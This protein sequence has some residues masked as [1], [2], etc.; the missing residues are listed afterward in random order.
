[1]VAPD[2]VAATIAEWQTRLLQLDRRN[3][4]L[5]FKAGRSSVRISEVDLDDFVVRLADSRSGLSFAYV[6][7]T[8]RPRALDSSVA[9]DPAQQSP[10]E[11]PGDIVADCETAD[12]QRRLRNLHRKDREWE[13]EQGV[14]ILFLAVGFLSWIDEDGESA[15]A[16]ILLA[17][18][19]LDQPSPR[20]P[21]R[22][23]REHDDIVVNVTLQYKLSRLNVALPD[24]DGDRSPSDFLADV[25][26]AIRSKPQW[27]VK[28]ELV[29]STFHY[30]KMSMWQDLE[31]L[32]L[33]GVAH[34]LVR[35]LAG[36]VSAQKLE[37][38]PPDA[39]FNRSLDELAGG[40]LDDA[41]DLQNQFLILPA[42]YSQIM[43]VEAARSGQHL[44]IHGP[45]GTGKS[46]TIANI[47]A[48]FLADG[49]RV[50]FVS[51]KTAALDV[52]KR[53]L[54]ECNLGTFCLDLHSV[55]GKKSNVYDQLRMSVDDPRKV[56]R[57]GFDSE[58]L[59][60]RRTA[61][62]ELVRAL[63]LVRLP[64]GRSVFQMN[65]SLAALRNAPDVNFSV[66]QPRSLTDPQ[67]RDFIELATRVAQRAPEFHA[68]FTSRWRPLRDTVSKVRLPDDIRS[69]MRMIRAALPP[70]RQCSSA[71]SDVTGLPPAQTLAQLTALAPVFNQLAVAPGVPKHW[72]SA[73]EISRLL[74][75]AVRQEAVKLERL[76]LLAQLAEILGAGGSSLN[77]HLL[78]PPFEE[79]IRTEEP[80]RTLLGDDWNIRLLLESETLQTAL[81]NLAPA[82]IALTQVD[83]RIADA[84]GLSPTT[85]RA[86]HIALVESAA[87]VAGLAPLPACWVLDSELQ[88][89]DSD[90]TYGDNRVEPSSDESRP[91]NLVLIESRVRAAQQV[92]DLLITAEGALFAEYSESL[93]ERVDDEMLI[94]YRTDHRRFLHR[95]GGQFKRDQRL[96]QGSRIS[97]GKIS[98]DDATAAVESALNVAALQQQWA[99][100]SQQLP[101]W[102]GHRFRGRE[103]DWQSI[104]D[105]LQRLAQIVSSIPL[106]DR[107]IQSLT[108]VTAGRSLGRLVRD[109]GD[110]L[111]DLS[112]VEVQLVG[113]ARLPQLSHPIGSVLTLTEPA[114]APIQAILGLAASLRPYL[115]RPIANVS[116]L[117]AVLAS[118]VKLEEIEAA[119]TAEASTLGNAFGDRF[120]GFETDWDDVE[121]AL[122]WAGGFLNILPPPL[123][124]QLIEQAVSPKTSDFYTQRRQEL[125]RSA[126]EC[127]AHLKQL[128]EQ[129][130]V[131][132]TAWGAWGAAR[133]S[134]LEAWADD[135]ET[136]ADSAGDW[137][138]Y[139]AYVAALENVTGSGVVSSIRE[140]TDDATLI[141]SVVQRRLVSAWLDDT[142]ATDAV[143]QQFAARE[144]ERVKDEFAALDRQFPVAARDEVRR[145][146]FST[147]PERYATQAGAGQ[148]GTL[149]AQL[150]RKRGQLPIRK[151]F[152]R[153]PTLLQELKP[154]LMM[155]PLAV[156]QL[157]PRSATASE[158]LSFDAVIF[159]EAS[160][161]FPEDAVPSLVR[162]QQAIVVGD[163]RQLPPTSFFRKAQGDE[164]EYSAEQEEED[165]ETNALRG[166]D[167][168][169]EAMDGMLGRGVGEKYLA[170]HYRSRHENLIRFSNHHFYDDRLLVFPSPYVDRS[171]LGVRGLY[172]EDGR[173][174]A[175]A[176]RTNQREADEVVRLVFEH[177]RTRPSNES[178][179]VVTLSR[180]QA[181]L[182][183][184]MIVQ[185]RI[186]E[187]DADERFDSAIREPFFVKNL[188][189]VQGDERDHI[190]LSV[191][192]GPTVGSGAVP[193]RFGPIN[194]DGGDRRLNVAV[195]RAR[196]SMTVV[197]S[198]RA[199][200]ITSQQR[201]SLLLRRYLEY[202]ANPL[203]AF[204]AQQTVDPTAEAE[205]PFEEA[206]IRA[207][208]ARGHRV[209]PQ[210]GV[211]GFRIDLG[212]YSQEGDRFDLGVECDGYTYHSSPAARDRDWLRQSILEGLGWNIHRVW[213][214][215]WIRNPD[216]QIRAIED[217]LQRA[218]IPTIAG[219]SNG[220]AVPARAPMSSPIDPER[221]AQPVSLPMPA[222]LLFEE[223]EEASLRGMR[224]GPELQFATQSE[225]EP[226]ILRIAE[227]EGPVHTDVAID[228][229]RQHYGMGKARQPSR[230]RV[231]SAV[232]TLARQTKLQIEKDSG[233]NDIFFALLE[234]APFPRRSGSR[235]GSRRPIN[236]IALSE[237]EVG[238]ER[239]ASALHGATRDELIEE[240]ARQFGYDRTGHHIAQRLGIAITSLVASG[241]LVE[242][243]GMLRLP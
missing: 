205:S 66:P 68:H 32:R 96:L 174:D 27:A 154:C 94:R 197:H 112:A 16:P 220:A 46:Q 53:R 60:R 166:R 14:N 11:I 163:E 185:R 226:I 86:S 135:L 84:M 91:S 13:E 216:E 127:D 116:E 33:E 95:F 133:W 156:S 169:L 190:I 142:Y 210:V 123:S 3:N 214:T 235:S 28:H 147:Y 48:T 9:T 157:L 36:D 221:D 52:V 243:F 143:F 75:I 30:S 152:M 150:S 151:L 219:A 104:Y 229:I 107:L 196:V 40:R 199:T 172:L 148:I 92:R 198:L 209:Q 38:P 167:S 113:E 93:V 240:T 129:F 102:L 191:G 128:N 76:R 67:Y 64:L 146:V 70:V 181:D 212:I 180:A 228:R 56:N 208:V 39:V 125:E 160:Q 175:G 77:F 18:C 178:I 31:Q 206:V 20:D 217:A 238:L 137:V 213:S 132:A 230:D 215:A 194:A 6:D 170:V 69:H 114:A 105:A 179:G 192:Y 227:V 72:L 47:I 97:P 21:F 34:A 103:T 24:F 99:S 4:L 177:M 25:E 117:A 108:N 118:G 171:D 223:Y 155:S 203:G 59:L 183:D 236:H 186:L 176:S 231:L 126:A 26:A 193:N 138:Q 222:Q 149:K 71:S 159:D 134:E 50:L 225:L 224:H 83:A 1:M 62:N 19:D 7:P 90:W 23:Q 82:I 45:P 109:A 44:V 202:L 37:P 2:V 239:A 187:R 74:N 87:S 233:S 111:A 54:V 115:V 242:S 101:S 232:R 79:A 17:P 98:I 131:E 100:L 124:E 144:H 57:V 12:L 158:T 29:L 141:P 15:T 43:A 120:A 140:V 165:E 130:S 78:A 161:V 49:K 85:S 106:N 22:L 81:G 164:D 145:R 61:L 8:Y 119:A 207:L 195:S 121:S 58:A 234:T 88:R 188:E 10:P 110:R 201:G 41:I 204:E 89:I 153:V 241:R 35:T 122:Q 211:A 55:R 136:N 5:Y 51:E 162:A 237:I 42:D 80:V 189:N 73:D 168:I 200:D 218:R 63:H 184:A 139:R 65:G 182:I 173:Y